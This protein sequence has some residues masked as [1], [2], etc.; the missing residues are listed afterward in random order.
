MRA[1]SLG[2]RYGELRSGLRFVSRL[3]GSR[4]NP[5]LAQVVVTRRCN[6]SRV[7]TVMGKFRYFN[8]GCQHHRAIRQV[9]GARGGT[10][11]PTPVKASG[12]KPGASTNFATLARI[13]GVM[14]PTAA[15]PLRHGA[16]SGP[17]RGV[18]QTS[19]KKAFY[20]LRRA[21]HRSG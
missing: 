14:P 3:L 6:L 2:R 11:T 21:R 13:V 7:S 19:A 15:R 9:V 1:P 4:H 5:L 20:P 16:A 10:R 17:R 18:V 8:Q 12:P